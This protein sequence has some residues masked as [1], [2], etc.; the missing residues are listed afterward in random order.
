LDGSILTPGTVIAADSEII[1][2]S[3]DI[4]KTAGESGFKFPW[5][6]LLALLGIALL[7]AIILLAPKFRKNEKTSKPAADNVPERVIEPATVLVVNLEEEIRFRAY[8]LYLERGGQNGD[9]ESDWHRAVCDISAKYKSSGYN[10][11]FADWFWWAS[12]ENRTTM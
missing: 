10:V 12:R 11:Y 9:A 5:K 4:E 8:E 3:A 2:L 6:F 7:I 1:I